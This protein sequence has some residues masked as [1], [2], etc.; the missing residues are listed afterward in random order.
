MP[1]VSGQVPDDQVPVAG[2]Q[3][4]GAGG[5][6]PVDADGVTRRNTL[7]LLGLAPLAAALGWS[8]GGIERATAYV[9]ALDGAAEDEAAAVLKFF[10]A[11]EWPTVRMLA[12]YI[13]PRDARSGSATDA[14]APEFIDFMM[15]DETTSDTSRVA[16]RGGLAWLDNESRARFGKRFIAASDA[17]RRQI[18]D[19]IAWPK[20]ARPEMGAG[21]A[22]FTRFRDA[23]ASAF[24]SSAEGWKD[25]K[26]VGNTFNP[27]WNG[28]PKPAL[29]KLG[30]SYEEFDA[31]LAAHRKS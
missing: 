22:F 30:V 12:D 8:N 3:V 18:L 23:V 16:M 2:G 7:K 20:K 19:D 6:V 13:I 31:S 5:Q 24:Y 9:A 21:V 17:Q 14:K 25:L 11:K 26:Y 10:T 15:M 28:C 27:N 29:D 1:V 4:P